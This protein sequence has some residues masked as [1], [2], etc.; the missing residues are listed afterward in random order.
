MKLLVAR[1]SRGVEG[2]GNRA[3]TERDPHGGSTLLEAHE[4]G[5]GAVADGER[6]NG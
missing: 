4:G 6:W 5:G 1:S 3:G 2:D